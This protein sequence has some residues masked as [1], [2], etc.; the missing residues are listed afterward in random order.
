MP[1]SW[2]T[3]RKLPYMKQPG[4]KPLTPIVT[5]VPKSYHCHVGGLFD[6]GDLVA[7]L[8]EM[9]GSREAHHAG[10]NYQHR[11]W[12]LKKREKKASTSVCKCLQVSASVYKCLQVSTSV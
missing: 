5:T 7:S 11:S 6:D 8:A 1:L 2:M 10:T 12:F 9:K 4:P 3:L